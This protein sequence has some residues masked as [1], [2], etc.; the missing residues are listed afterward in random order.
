[1]I[2]WKRVEDLQF[3][4]CQQA[5]KNYSNS[6]YYVYKNVIS[7]NYRVCIGQQ[8][9]DFVFETENMQEVN[10]FFKNLYIE[11]IAF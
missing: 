1:M 7:N 2:L 9:S 11:Y 4:L 8:A 5:Y 3:K 10:D 6:D